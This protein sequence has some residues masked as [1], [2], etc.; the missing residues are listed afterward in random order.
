MEAYIR[1][2][3]NDRVIDSHELDYTTQS[4]VGAL[5]HARDRVGFANKDATQEEEAPIKVTVDF[6]DVPLATVNNY[7]DTFLLRGLDD[8][9]VVDYCDAMKEADHRLTE[10]V[11]SDPELMK[12]IGECSLGQLMLII[13]EIKTNIDNRNKKE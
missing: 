4:R 7:N 10:A 9:T 1:F 6:S 5:L 11:E 13:E 8:M 12:A 2:R 3:Y